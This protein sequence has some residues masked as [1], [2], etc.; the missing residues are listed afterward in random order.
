M[1]KKI[2]FLMAIAMFLIGGF[3]VIIPRSQSDNGE[4]TPMSP[5]IPKRDETEAIKA[6]GEFVISGPIMSTERE[7]KIAGGLVPSGLL[8]LRAKSEAE[9]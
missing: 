6:T 4:Q 1:T 5:I 8:A 3:F 9:K 2:T 7:E